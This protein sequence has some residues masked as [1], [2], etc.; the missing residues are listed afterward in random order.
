VTPSVTVASP[1]DESAAVDEESTTE[2]AAAAAV[3]VKKP[4]AQVD[5]QLTKALEILRAK[6]A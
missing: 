6:A 5:N 3:P 1:V 2:G 4:E